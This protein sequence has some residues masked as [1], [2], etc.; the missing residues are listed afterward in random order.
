[1][2]ESDF[3]QMIEIQEKL[4]NGLAISNEEKEFYNG[5]YCAMLDYLEDTYFYWLY[6]TKKI[7]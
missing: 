4:K 6:N 3:K 7:N 2:K 1:M 5:N